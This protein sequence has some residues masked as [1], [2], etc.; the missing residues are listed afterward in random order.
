MGRRTVHGRRWCW[1]F[2]VVWLV[3]GAAS[4]RATE[5]L[6]PSLLRD[7]VATAQWTSPT[8]LVIGSSFRPGEPATYEEIDAETGTRQPL[9]GEAAAR[10]AVRRLAP[11]PERSRNSGGDTSI[12]FRNM[13]AQSVDL[14]WVDQGGRRQSYGQVA[15]GEARSQHTFVGHAWLV[16]EAGEPLGWIRGEPR[17]IE[18]VIDAELPAKQQERSGRR[19]QSD[20]PPNTPPLPEPAQA[21]AGPPVWSP[22]GQ[23]VVVWEVTPAQRHE[24]HLV[25]SAPADRVEPRLKTLDYLKPGDVIEQ[26]WP[27]LF[28]REGTE[29]AIDRTL[30]ANPWSLDRLRWADN[31]SQFTML[32]NE[33]GHQVV[34]LVAV[35]AGSGVARTVV[36]EVS[37]TFV[38]YAHKTW[39]HWLSAE[40]LVWMSERDGY[41]HLWLVDVAT[42][43]LRQITSGS[44]MV[45]EVQRVDDDARELTL[46]V[47]GINPGEDPYHTHVVRAAIDSGAMVKLTVGNGTHELSWSPDRRWYVDSFSRVDLP[48]VHEL[49][50]ADDGGLVCELGR[51]DASLLIDQ[52]WVM[53]ER[54]VAKGRDAA[55]DIYGVIYRPRGTV[56]D[57][58]QRPV[59]EQIYAGPHG[60]HVPVSFSVNH[61]QQ[62]FTD[63]GFVLVRIDGMGTNWRGKAFHDVCWK[64]LRDAGFP[65]RVAWLRAAAATRP[66]M[67]LDRVGIFGGSAGGQNAL[68]GL[69]SYPEIYKVGVAD[70]GCHDNRMD[71][72]WWNELWMGWPVDEAYETSSNVVDAQILQG[73]LMLIVGELDENV[74]PAST[75]QVS[76]ALVR[77]GKDHELVVI[78]GAGHGAAETP[79][80]SM[81]R[82]RF[83]TEHLHPPPLQ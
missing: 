69:L 32:Y 5:R 33:R 37:P 12:L 75:L 47:L 16:E 41:N 40:E 28:T 65:D 66:W 36:E 50:S 70:C 43:S 80:G 34:R 77:A 3:A 52:G 17:P 35:D 73:E 29:I 22:D 9:A 68:R 56:N 49:R 4:V 8:T 60:F 61:G 54:F 72:I 78:P 42:G 63:E 57:A 55:T 38:D 23:R 82:L 11:R 26:R 51:A 20:P 67:D 15:P 21:L 62:K 76:A 19:Q 2:T 64:N 1:G 74:D 44:W 83:L 58:Q 7:P 25:E 53:P 59:V 13:R 24:V 14:F 27:R 10:A 81:K 39:M 45:R 48:P 6:D 71:K 46:S 18:I 30:F 31:S 79:Y